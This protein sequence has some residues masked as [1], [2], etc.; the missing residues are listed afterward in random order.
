MKDKRY[1]SSIK[2]YFGFGISAFRVTLGPFVDGQRGIHVV[3]R[4]TLHSTIHSTIH[5]HA[6]YLV[7]RCIYVEITLRPDGGTHSHET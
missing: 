6:T 1:N 4:D 2:K 5:V 7:Q 3:K